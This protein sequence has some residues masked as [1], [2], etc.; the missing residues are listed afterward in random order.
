M[1]DRGA[2]AWRCWGE[3]WV[4]HDSRSA[5][6]HLLSDTAGAV[7]QEL[8]VTG[9]CLSTGDIWHRLFAEGTGK[10]SPEEPTLTEWQSLAQM[11]AELLHLGLIEQCQT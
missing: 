2:L 10:G 11:L 4:V 3:E 1:A 5:T 7:L 6:T 8:L 9:D